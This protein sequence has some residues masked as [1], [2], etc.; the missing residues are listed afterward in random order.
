MSDDKD[1]VWT[2]AQEPGNEAQKFTREEM[3]EALRKVS[4]AE[5]TV[6]FVAPDGSLQEGE[7][8]FTEEELA[9]ARS[10]FEAIK[11]Q[12]AEIIE[13]LGERQ[14]SMPS[15]LAT[16]MSTFAAMGVEM[17][18]FKRSKRPDRGSKHAQTVAMAK[19]GRKRLRKAA[20]RLKA[21]RKEDLDEIT[22][23]GQEI[24]KHS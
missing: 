17:P 12:E 21:K 2:A 4:A 22:R 19:A 6:E 13:K 11:Q 9:A 10:K 14:I 8:A 1:V 18:S 16:L 7:Y 20:K 24:E 3:A 15:N 5:S 23:I